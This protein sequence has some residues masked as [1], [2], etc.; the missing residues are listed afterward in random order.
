[1]PARQK[2]WKHRLLYVGRD[3][4]LSSFLKDALNPLD[5]FVVRCPG[6]RESRLFIASKI[7]Y[8]LFLFDDELPDISG[9][10]LKRF[11]HSLAHR[12]STPVILYKKSDDFNLLVETIIRELSQ[13]KI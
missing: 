7:K 2:H 9:K 12:Q 13:I 5:C 1:M 8:S 10:E 3:L 6:G 4:V 11:A